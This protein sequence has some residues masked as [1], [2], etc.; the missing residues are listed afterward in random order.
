MQVRVI[1]N[2]PQ[3]AFE[4]SV[5]DGVETYESTFVKGN[6]KDFKAIWRLR[7][8]DDAATELSLE[9]FLQPSI[10][11]PTNL[12]NGENLGGSSK[13]VMAM[14]ARAEAIAK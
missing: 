1:D 7:K 10:P 3:V 11:M 13:G 2:P 5:I 6:V 12:M 9:V 8:L 4:V 14:R